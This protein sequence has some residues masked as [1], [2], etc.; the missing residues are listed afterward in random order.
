MY[1]TFPDLVVAIFMD[2]W[3]AHACFTDL[4]NCVLSESNPDGIPAWKMFS[5]SWWTNVANSLG[6]QWT[7]SPE[8]YA[9][10]GYVEPNTYLGY[11]VESA[12]RTQ[13]FIP[14]LEREDHAYILTKYFFNFDPGTRAWS[15]NVFNEASNKT[16]I[17]YAVGLHPDSQ[18]NG[19]PELPANLIDYGLLPRPRFLENLAKSKIL[20][21]MSNPVK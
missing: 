7:F 17:R 1:L 19:E 8:D 3:E 10:E 6:R 11:S 12:C 16:G 15:P 9:V 14:H 21:G 4:G 5:F 13:P 2:A 20:I 18:F